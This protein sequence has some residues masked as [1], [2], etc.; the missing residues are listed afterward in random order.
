MDYEMIK[1]RWKNSDSKYIS[2]IFLGGEYY[3]EIDI[4]GLFEVRL[5]YLRLYSCYDSII[6]D[7][8]LVYYY[9]LDY[10]LF[11]KENDYT[12]LRIKY[13]L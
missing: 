1:Y 12:L 9:D 10:C 11:N 8:L 7:N 4:S 6:T 5:P 2:D 13:G 3:Q